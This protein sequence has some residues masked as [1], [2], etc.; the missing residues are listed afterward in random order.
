MP[1]FPNN[2]ALS[3]PFLMRIWIFF[4]GHYGTVKISGVRSSASKNYSCT[5]LN[6]R[7]SCLLLPNLS[8]GISRNFVVN[9]KEVGRFVGRFFQPVI[10]LPLCSMCWRIPSSIRRRISNNIT[11]ITQLYFQNLTIQEDK[12]GQRLILS[13]T[14][15][16]N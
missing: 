16:S 14:P 3:T 7:A 13:L 5:G 15:L 4:I 9:I 1:V 2:I 12:G 6:G 10:A 11:K 8:T